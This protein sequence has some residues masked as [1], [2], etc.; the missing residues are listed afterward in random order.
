MMW[1]YVLAVIV[2]NNVVTTKTFCKKPA[3]AK[4]TGTQVKT[5]Q[6]Q[7]QEKQ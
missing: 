4:N 6:A 3:Y 5:E 7:Q 2:G 1:S